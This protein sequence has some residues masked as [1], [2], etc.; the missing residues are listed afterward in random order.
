MGYLITALVVFLAA[1][2]IRPINPNPKD[3]P[4]LNPPK[5]WLGLK[6]KVS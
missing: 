2:I 5:S 1:Y 6:E 3:L 4:F